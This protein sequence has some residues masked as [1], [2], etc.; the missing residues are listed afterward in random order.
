M[1]KKY[2]HKEILG[3]W[4]DSPYR[5]ILGLGPSSAQPDP[6]DKVETSWPVPARGLHA[7]DKS[8]P[9]VPIYTSS[10]IKF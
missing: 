7:Y 6:K 3:M 8:R 2:K 1:K 5:A 4:P 9:Q 10:R